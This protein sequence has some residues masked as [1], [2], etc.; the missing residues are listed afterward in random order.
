MGR[1]RGAD[2]LAARAT[3][4]DAAERGEGLLAHVTVLAQ[5]VSNPV[6]RAGHA[7]HSH[8]QGGLVEE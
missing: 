7:F 5:L 2:A 3:V 4:V 1:A 6:V 8:C